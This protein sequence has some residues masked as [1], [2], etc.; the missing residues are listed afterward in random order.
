ML[1]GLSLFLIHP[2]EA[3][4]LKTVSPLIKKNS[5]RNKILKLS[6]EKTAQ[7]LAPIFSQVILK[8]K[9][10]EDLLI[11]L[12]HAES[13]FKERSVS[14]TGDIGLG[15]I[16]PKVWALEFKRLKIE[17]NPKRLK[18]PKYNLEKTA[19]ILTIMK[20]RYPK[21]PLWYARYHSSTTEF[22]NKYARNIYSRYKTLRK[23]AQ[24]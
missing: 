9:I 20:N 17:F 23:V 6:D 2:V 15:Q 12:V 22:K 4:T 24:N 3:K 19:L 13:S 8:Y 11:G 5:I 7:R 21:D 16:N 10:S 14:S 18:E 1:L